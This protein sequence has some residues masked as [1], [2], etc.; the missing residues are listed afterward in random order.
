MPVT[1]SESGRRKSL[2][3]RWTWGTAPD[4]SLKALADEL[5]AGR[6]PDEADL[7][8]RGDRRAVWALPRVGGGVLLKHFRVRRWEP[9][10]FLVRPS[11]A[12]AEYRSAAQ[13]ARL[14]VATPAPLGFGERRRGGLLV[15][16]WSLARL[17]PGAVTLGEELNRATAAGDEAA[18]AHWT[19]AAMRTAA[20]LHRLP[21][22]HRDLHANN[23]LLGP[24]G[25][26]L[27]IDLH[28]MRSASGL[29]R[30]QRLEN[31][32]RLVFSIRAAVD[33]RDAGALAAEYSTARGEPDEALATDLAAALDAFERSYVDGRTARCLVDS[34]LFTAERLHDG[35][36]YRRREYS[37]ERLRSD[38]LRHA[39]AARAG[40]PGLLGS[41]PRARVTR[42][43]DDAGSRIVKEYLRAGRFPRLRHGLRLGRARTAW[44]ASRR[45][46]VLGLPTPQA[47]ALIE[48]S[49]GSAALVTRRIEGAVTLRAWLDVLDARA[50]P[51]E[52]RLLAA[53]VG[54]VVGRLA[55]AGL[56]HDDLS[57]KNWLVGD[58]PPPPPRDRRDAGAPPWP[59]VLLIDLDNLRTVP[60][61]DDRS[62]GRMLAQLADVPDGVTRT[63]R[64]RFLRA[65]ERAAGRPLPPEV[66]RG[67]LDGAR[68]RAARRAELDRRRPA[69][70]GSAPAPP[71]VNQTPR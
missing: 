42:V 64:L 56:R 13:L 18:I 17:V 59:G 12:A 35:R 67:A 38:L 63:D 30:R 3:I 15:E 44:V 41:T 43:D 46:D 6:A 21:L 66:A 68:R 24:D 29:S 45:L 70:V 54:H 20:A 50:R 28:S 1:A 58:E 19:A 11:R 14:G 60:P 62:L 47:L 9:L 51:R 49:D 7:V 16:A 55:R 5:E 25:S 69:A 40:G 26:L 4:E 23:L 39:Q 37:I 34:T 57:T 53:A 32:A 31:L 71:P 48:R 10:L 33:L 36:V 2:P 27:V 61:H 52:R 8:K 22:L 65:Y